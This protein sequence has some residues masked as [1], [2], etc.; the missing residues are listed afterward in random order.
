VDA[1]RRSAILTGV[2][3]IFGTVLGLV[4]LGAVLQPLLDATDSLTAYGTMESRVLIASLLELLMGV[5]LVAMAVAVYPVLRRFSPSA[6]VAYLSA[7]VLEAVVYILGVL[8]ML[9]LVEVGKE[10]VEAGSSDSSYHALGT[11]LVGIPDWAGHA[12]LDVAIFPLG[13]FVLYWVFFRT[14]LV[15]RW[16]SGWGL[17][18]ALLYWAAGLLVMFN[19][20]EP[21][22]S[23]HIALQAPLGLQEMVLALWLI[24][25]GFNPSAFASI[26][27]ARG[28]LRA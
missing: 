27:P 6:A 1:D 17:V 4:G 2:F 15:P 9:A 28:I 8:S 18:G 3:F 13:A 10:Y 25:K 21:L 19:V 7:R 12:I 26:D 11:V 5:S 14:K 23:A 20:I 16:L 24:I 22:E